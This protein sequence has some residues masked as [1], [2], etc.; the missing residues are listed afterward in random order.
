MKKRKRRLNIKRGLKRVLTFF[1]VL[2]M[3]LLVM[4]TFIPKSMS[5]DMDY[6]KY[7]VKNGDSLWNISC[8]FSKDN[9]D[10]RKMVYQIK[11]INDIT[12][13]IRPGQ[14][15][16]IPDYRQAEGKI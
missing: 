13:E 6:I 11:K 1:S 12:E 9:I 7:T 10:P 5:S 3:F 8:E 2:A 15:I 16:V 4:N 14:S